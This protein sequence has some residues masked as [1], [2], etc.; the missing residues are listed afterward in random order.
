MSRQGS[1][2]LIKIIIASRLWISLKWVSIY[3]RED[4]LLPL[5]WERGNTSPLEIPFCHDW[6]YDE[7]FNNENTNH[8][9]NYLILDIL[10]KTLVLGRKAVTSLSNLTCEIFSLFNGNS[11]QWYTPICFEHFSARFLLLIHI[12]TPIA[13]T[14]LA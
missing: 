14:E 9:N 7:D 4:F 10:M 13:H 2:T 8:L 11:S 5:L 12:K 3:N 6:V 1:P